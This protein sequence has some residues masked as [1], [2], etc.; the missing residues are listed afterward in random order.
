LFLRRK[1]CGSKNALA[2]EQARADIAAGGGRSWQ[3][4]LDPPRLDFIDEA[5]IKLA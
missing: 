2:L 1:G 3:A 4:R 5:R